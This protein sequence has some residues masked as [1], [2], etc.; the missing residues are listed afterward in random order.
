MI[1][2]IIFDFYDVIHGDPYKRWLE[3]RGLKREG[4]YRQLSYDL[5]VGKIN[6]DQFIEELSQLSSESPVAVIKEFES[7][8]K[9]DLNIVDLIDKLHKKYRTAL[10]SNS[11]G[12][13]LRARLLKYDLESRIR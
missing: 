7:V 6:S 1:K 2:V 8:A 3:R 11:P 13:N 9:V 5:D 10:L 4:R 12:E